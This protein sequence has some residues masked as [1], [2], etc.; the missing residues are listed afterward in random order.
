MSEVKEMFSTSNERDNFDSD[1]DEDDELH[2][3]N[4]DYLSVSNK[5][6]LIE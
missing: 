6:D 2:I 4:D 3:N 1:D 5:N